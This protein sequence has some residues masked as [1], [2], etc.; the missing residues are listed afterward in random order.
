MLSVIE[1]KMCP[2]DRKIWS[3][4]LEKER[5]PATFSGLMERMT[6]E[7]K[8][9]MRAV[10]S[11]RSAGLCRRNV[12]HIGYEK[13]QKEQHK[14]WFCKNSTHWP[15]QCTKLG[16][17]NVEERINNAN[18]AARVLHVKFTAPVDLSE[19]WKTESMGVLV[20]PCV[21]EA[22]KLSQVEREEKV[23]I[24]KSAQNIVNQW[25]VP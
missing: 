22:D 14:C 12:N 13:D 9:R 8:S 17:M 2:S 21:C 19:F 24:D 5:K 4:D 11:I 10:A 6:V 18:P 1:R 3:R 7:M 23:L 20:K 15:D 16:S 25:M